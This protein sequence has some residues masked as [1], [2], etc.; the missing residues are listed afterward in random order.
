MA[1]K[2]WNVTTDEG[3]FT[4]DL[5]GSKISI[6]GGAPT[7][8]RKFAKKTHFVDTEYT[9]PIG[10]RSAILFIQSFTSPVLSYNGTNC[11]TGQP[12]AY[13]KIPVWAWIII[14]LE[15]V[16]L[17]ILGGSAWITLIAMIATVIISRSSLNQG[18]K[19]ILSIVL[20]IGV[21]VIG[22]LI[23][24]AAAAVGAI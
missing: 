3:T 8:L 18:V 17:F 5:K 11:A 4:V 14:V 24:T 19:I 9:I 12:W 21:A 15:L 2:T 16:A 13:Q 20:L 7:P 6:N 23:G 22:F 10:N 1:K